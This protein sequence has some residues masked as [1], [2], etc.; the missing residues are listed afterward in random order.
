MVSGSGKEWRTMAPYSPYSAMMVLRPQHFSVLRHFARRFWN[1]T[2]A[3]KEKQLCGQGQKIVGVHKHRDVRAYGRRGGKSLRFVIT[4]WDEGGLH[5]SLL[6]YALVSGATLGVAAKRRTTITLLRIQI[7]FSASDNLRRIN[8][9]G[10]FVPFV[11][12]VIFFIHS[13]IHSFSIVG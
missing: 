11:L 13:A 7:K 1:Q 5:N 9:K 3:H 12:F 8:E 10:L 4:I 6:K 2:C